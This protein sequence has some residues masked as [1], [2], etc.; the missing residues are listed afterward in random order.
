MSRQSLK[1]GD[2]EDC[3]VTDFVNLA[4]LGCGISVFLRF[5]EKIYDNL[6]IY[7]DFRNV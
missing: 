5:L 4:F 2:D 6:N 1:M 3:K 7:E